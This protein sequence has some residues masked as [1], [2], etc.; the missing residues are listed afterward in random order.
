LK[1]FS[2][3]RFDRILGERQV[4]ASALTL[5][6]QDNAGLQALRHA[7]VLKGQTAE[8]KQAATMSPG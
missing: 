1:D 5:G 4:R 8:V 2:G 7:L 6:P 3:N